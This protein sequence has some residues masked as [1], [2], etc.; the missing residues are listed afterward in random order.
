MRK[1]QNIYLSF[2]RLAVLLLSFILMIYLGAC[3]I[4]PHKYLEAKQESIPTT[5]VN[6]E[7]SGTDYSNDET[8]SDDYWTDEITPS[9]L[10]AAAVWEIPANVDCPPF[11]PSSQTLRSIIVFD[12]V[13]IPGELTPCYLVRYN[14]ANSLVTENT[15]YEWQYSIDSNGT[16]TIYPTLEEEYVIPYEVSD[17]ELIISPSGQ[18]YTLPSVD[19]ANHMLYRASD[20]IVGTWEAYGHSCI[21]LKLGVTTFGNE[22]YSLSFF[23][24]GT[25]NTNLDHGGVYRI[26][27]D[28]TSL[29]MEYSLSGDDLSFKI[30]GGNIML[31]ENGYTESKDGAKQYSILGRADY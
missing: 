3:K 23:K 20:A 10:I 25:F 1:H 11:I 31:L 28:G 24:D 4:I 21:Q 5:I 14:P 6:P 8:L 13:L 17:S 22:L 7:D 9:D 27:H 15:Y 16:L 30:L 29:S 2:K 12:D 18:R 26:I 19:Y